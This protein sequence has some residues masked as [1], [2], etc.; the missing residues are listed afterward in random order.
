MQGA[1]LDRYASVCRARGCFNKNVDTDGRSCRFQSFG[2]WMLLA[3]ATAIHACN[4]SCIACSAQILAARIWLMTDMHVAALTHCIALNSSQPLSAD[5]CPTTDYPVK[6]LLRVS[7]QKRC[8]TSMLDN[9]TLTWMLCALLFQQ[10]EPSRSR[11]QTAV[12]P[13]VTQ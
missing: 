3:L 9:N 2:I 7:P 10:Q 6:A 1:P 13:V 5:L 8:L 4:A 11:A 12:L